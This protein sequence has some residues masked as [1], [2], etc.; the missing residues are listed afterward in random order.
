MPDERLALRMLLLT[1]LAN[2]GLS[3]ISCAQDVAHIKSDRLMMITMF[4][5][6]LRL[7]GLLH[8]I[9]NLV[10]F[11]YRTYIC[12]CITFLML[13]LFCFIRFLLKKYNH[14]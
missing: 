14:G 7:Y 2:S 9:T 8:A 11:Q 3:F 5:I 13:V 12:V 1:L 6:I 10:F 4:F